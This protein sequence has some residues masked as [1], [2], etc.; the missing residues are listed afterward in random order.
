MER[1]GSRLLELRGATVRPATDIDT[2]RAIT[3][4]P[5]VVQHIE[6]ERWIWAATRV[7]DLLEH[8]AY[9]QAYS[10]L[11]ELL[12]VAHAGDRK[13]AQVLETVKTLT[14]ETR[15]SRAARNAEQT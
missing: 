3:S 7:L 4:S 10:P 6:A 9:A 5:E 13:A 2:A 12:A 15:N 11:A 8:G 14:R 1:R